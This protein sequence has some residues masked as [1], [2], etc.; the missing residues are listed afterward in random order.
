MKRG[1]LAW[2]IVL[3]FIL[4]AFVIM[5]MAKAGEDGLGLSHRDLVDKNKV[6]IHLE[7][8]PEKVVYLAEEFIVDLLKWIGYQ[9]QV[10]FGA[11]FSLLQRVKFKLNFRLLDLRLEKMLHSRTL[12]P[13]GY[14]H[15]LVDKSVSDLAESGKFVNTAKVVGHGP[16]DTVVYDHDDAVVQLMHPVIQIEKS[17]AHQQVV[18][19]QQ[20][21]FTITVTNAGDVP[22]RKVRVEDPQAPDCESVLGRL[23]A[24]ESRVY[25]CYVV[26]EGDIDNIAT[27]SGYDPNGGVVVASAE[28]SVDTINPSI[29][30]EKTPD[31]K[32]V[33]IGKPI[34]FTVT[35]TNT[36]D[37]PLHQVK[38]VDPQVPDCERVIDFL[39]VLDTVSYGCTAGTVRNEHYGYGPVKVSHA[40][41]ANS[42]QEELVRTASF[43]SWLGCQLHQTQAGFETMGSGLFVGACQTDG[44][45]WYFSV[46]KT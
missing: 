24:G 1:V 8:N 33:V 38:V 12:T 17:P 36:G 21:L 40:E 25:Q 13:K 31:H 20:V 27:A 45:D 42:P 11:D 7:Y 32:R 3:L 37:V 9:E 5:P 18:S 6:L 43:V 39:D 4:T 30:I 35:V 14:H 19:G 2:S 28:A 44:A 46:W 10:A 29:K 22:L 41:K 16:I 15:S 26:A 23:E 34:T